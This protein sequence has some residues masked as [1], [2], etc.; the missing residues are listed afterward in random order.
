V[1]DVYGP[2]CDKCAPEQIVHRTGKAIIGSLNLENKLENNVEKIFTYEEAKDRLTEGFKAGTGE[3][4]VECVEIIL[5]RGLRKQGEGYCFT[6]DSR[7][8]L[9]AIWGQIYG[10]PR[11]FLLELAKNLQLPHLIVKASPGYSYGEQED[12]DE[13][14]KIYTE[15]DKFS[16]KTIEGGHH[17]HMTNPERVL[18]VIN[19][20]IEV[21][22]L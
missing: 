5:K 19:D 18:P 9:W 20:F 13:V 3:I 4:P 11:S 12:I 10:I 1:L 22:K 14:L 16:I 7:F 6:W 15:N 17:V 8:L 21:N 2:V